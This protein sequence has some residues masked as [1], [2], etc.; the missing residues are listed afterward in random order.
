MRI[1]LLADINSVHT[2][3]WAQGLSEQ[4]LDIG[5]FSLNPPDPML[6][7][8]PDI[9][10][11]I[12]GNI[13]SGLASSSLMAKT[14]YLFYIRELKRAITIFRPA[15]VHAH[16]ASSYGTL[17]NL[18]G[19]HPFFISL[20]GSDVYDF[21]KKNFLTRSLLRFNLSAADLILSTSHAMA[22]EASLYTR[23]HIT[24]IPFGIDLDR[25]RPIIRE[26]ALQNEKIIIGTAKALESEYG[27][28]YLIRA[29][30]LVCQRNPGN[31]LFLKIAGG[32]SLEGSLK[33]LALAT[34]FGDRIEFAGKLDH[35]E[36][37]SFLRQLDIFAA[38]SLSESFGVSVIEA[39]AC[40]IPVLVS[41]IG[42]LQEVVDEDV[43]GIVVPAK[44]V[45]A[46]ASALE[47]L[48]LSTELRIRLGRNGREKVEKMYDWKDNITVMVKT[49]QLF[50]SLI[51]LFCNN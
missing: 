2:R 29:F 18:S 44:D 15:L 13:S 40:S 10:V 50:F 16:Y 33:A 31:S 28:E 17:G 26:G 48:V 14:K 23:K 51:F 5:V 19:F 25:F 36:I 34:G 41:R 30:A 20:W 3:R 32:G 39:S 9:K 37:P 7:P 38:L 27:I 22:K 49:Y 6:K 42:G 46:S 47:S 11:F 35:G 12:P 1:L 45:E 8:V 24:V 4:G 43:T 21:P